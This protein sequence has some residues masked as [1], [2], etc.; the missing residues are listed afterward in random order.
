MACLNCGKNKPILTRGV[1]AACYY[2]MRYAVKRGEVTDEE[3]LEAGLW[4][5]A[6]PGRKPI[7]DFAA[8]VGK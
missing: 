7:E 8:K 4:T 1:C 3:L 2:R 5:K 6:K